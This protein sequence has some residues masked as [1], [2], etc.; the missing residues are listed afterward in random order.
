MNLTTSAGSTKKEPLKSRSNIT[1][2]QDSLMSSQGAALQF[3]EMKHSAADTDLGDIDLVRNESACLLSKQ[4]ESLNLGNSVQMGR[5]AQS[6]GLNDPQT[7]F[8]Q[9]I[10]NKLRSLN[11][12]IENLLDDIKNIEQIIQEEQEI[13]NN[14]LLKILNNKNIPEKHRRK[15]IESISNNLEKY[16][17][18]EKVSQ[19]IKENNEKLNLELETY[20]HAREKIISI[21]Q[22][23]SKTFEIT[24]YTPYLHQI[25]KIKACTESLNQN[26]EN[27]VISLLRP[28]S[29]NKLLVLPRAGAYNYDLERLTNVNK[30]AKKDIELLFNLAPEMCPNF[31]DIQTRFKSQLDRLENLEEEFKNEILKHIEGLKDVFNNK[32]LIRQHNSYVETCYKVCL[33]SPTVKQAL[34]TK[35]INA[36]GI[37]VPGDNQ[38]H[39]NQTIYNEKDLSEYVDRLNS[40]DD[41]QDIA[42]I[43]ARAKQVTSK[44]P[45]KGLRHTFEETILKKAI[46]YGKPLFAVCAGS[47][48]VAEALDSTIIKHNKSF[49]KAKKIIA[50]KRNV[51]NLY[52]PTEIDS[53]VTIQA[54]PPSQ[55]ASSNSGIKIS[56]LSPQIIID[57][58]TSLAKRFIEGS[59][60]I[61]STHWAHIKVSEDKEPYGLQPVLH[62]NG[63]TK[64]AESTAGTP[65]ILSQWH[66]E[67]LKDQTKTEDP[68]VNNGINL[69]KKV[70]REMLLSAKTQQ[71]KKEVLHDINPKEIKKLLQKRSEQDWSSKQKQREYRRTLK[72]SYY[73]KRSTAIANSST[74]VTISQLNKF[75]KLDLDI[76]AHYNINPIEIMRLSNRDFKN[77]YLRPYHPDR[78]NGTGNERLFKAINAVRI[79][80]KESTN[81]STELIEDKK[82]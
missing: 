80:S 63:I 62:A 4:T 54:I 67:Y 60:T 11:K 58:K 56:S 24:I 45:Y 8:N 25:E 38:Q 33:K 79:V 26:E 82:N 32:H 21:Q 41:K 42:I 39:P 76:L 7:N 22:Q 81:N 71:R 10:S 70:I 14:R 72:R 47:W 6:V 68:S 78:T 64:L 75:N 20:V 28:H 46:N 30:G 36:S 3:K 2:Q 53:A 50:A 19:L 12:K 37:F 65:M 9:L 52:N 16:N 61:N 43:K 59:A 29:K 77:K 66:P 15:A 51:S 1:T 5:L 18:P 74:L 13:L 35:I 57:D 55:F 44:V 49:L 27:H 17:T 40:K 69:S 48:R 23:L 73:R 31:K 34:F